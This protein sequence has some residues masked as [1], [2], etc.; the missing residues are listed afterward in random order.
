MEYAREL[1]GLGGIYLVDTNQFGLEGYGAAYIVDA[2]VAAIVETGLSYSAPR[3]LRALAELG[4]SPDE[5]GFILV[6]HVHLDHAG[7]AGPL[8][9]ACPN[10]TVA[11]HERGAKH[12][13]KPAYL[14]KSVRDATGPMFCHY[15]QAA[16]IPRERLLELEGGEL[17]SLGEGF[18]IRAIATPGH[19][20][21]HLCFFE[22]KTRSLFTGD[23][24]GIYWPEADRLLPTTPP[25]S[26]DLERSLESVQ[27]LR[28]LKPERLLYTH[29]GEHDRPAAM[30]QTYAKLLQDWV[31]EI[32]SLRKQLRGDGAVKQALLEEYGPFLEGLYDP[33]MVEHEITMNA[34]GVLQYLDRS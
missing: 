12:L 5:V 15:G 16:P 25:P 34:Q 32:R 13:V 17:F 9:Q 2:P 28:A 24:A 20:P 33:Q 10:A 11:A 23:A 7:G 27:L 18:Q 6:S 3:I 26:F 29:F 1:E 8:A 31:E 14:V 4:L 21:H 22:Q 19:A 30:L